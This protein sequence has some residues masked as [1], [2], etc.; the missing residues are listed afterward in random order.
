LDFVDETRTLNPIVSTIALIASNPAVQ[1][2]AA[3]LAVQRVQPLL[4]KVFG[5]RLEARNAAEAA[6][7]YAATITSRVAFTKNF[8]HVDHPVHIRRFYRPLKFKGPRGEPVDDNL[9]SIFKYGHAVALVGHAGTGK[10]TTLKHLCLEAIESGT[11]VPIF[12][13]LRRLIE[14]GKEEKRPKSIKETLAKAL[15]RN[16]LASVEPALDH[17]LSEPNLLVFLDGFDELPVGYRAIYANELLTLVERFTKT[18][19]IVSTRPDDM[20]TGLNAI[21]VVTPI[22]LT[23]KQACDHVDRFD[24]NQ[25]QE[26]GFQALL[27]ES[28]YEDHFTFASNPLLLAVLF[29]TYRRYYRIAERPHLFFDEVYEALCSNHDRKKGGFERELA[30]Q[31]PIEDF[32]QMAQM[33]CFIAAVREKLVFNQSGLRHDLTEVIGALRLDTT[34]AAA[35]KDLVQSV[36][37]LLE[38]GF[39]FVFLHKS[40]QEFLAAKYIVTTPNL[41]QDT[42]LASISPDPQQ[43]LALLVMF[44][45]NKDLTEDVFLLPLMESI[46]AT[47]GAL[48][49]EEQFKRYFLSSLY[50]S[51]AQPQTVDLPRPW[52]GTIKVTSAIDLLRRFY[53]HLEPVELKDRRQQWW[54]GP[55]KSIFKKVKDAEVAGSQYFEANG[56]FGGA[57]SLL[58]FS[59]KAISNLSVLR[60]QVVAN[61]LIRNN[62][63][64]RVEDLVNRT[65]VKKEPKPDIRHELGVVG[66]E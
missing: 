14:H 51:G 6:K 60:D 11:R 53:P 49:V 44:G 33:F 39:E 47:Y 5:K 17:L 65:L 41:R 43:S 3:D 9:G 63:V 57:E 61:Q 4:V 59:P 62:S 15:L 19:W 48:I 1:K 54:I 38:D 40:L 42:A 52:M 27:A 37:L 55:D 66:N 23:L 46:L 25:E 31:L 34:A 10:S 30:T 50:E 64:K 28:L 58:G 56:H 12:V 26:A 8:L 16:E 29:L 7:L 32:N 22:P 35:Q 21:R 36:S 2:A 13:E 18:Q 45:L 20:V 24:I